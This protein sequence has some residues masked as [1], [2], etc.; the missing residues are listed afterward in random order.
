M[1]LI[2]RRRFPTSATSA[3]EVF[4]DMKGTGASVVSCVRIL[5]SALGAMVG[6]VLEDVDFVA[7]GFYL[8]ISSVIP[9]LLLLR[10]PA[11]P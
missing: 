10:L 1:A 4:D 9:L 2:S 3:L 11:K 8:L 5:L 6:G 7:T